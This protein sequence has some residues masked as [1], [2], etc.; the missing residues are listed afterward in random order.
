MK[1]LSAEELFYLW[2]EC[3]N[4]P[5]LAKTLLLLQQACNI[6]DNSVITSMSIGERNARLLQ[7]QEWIFGNKMFH[8]TYCQNCNEKLEWETDTTSMF[9][10]NINNNFIAENYTL[11]FKGYEIS[12]RLINNLDILNIQKNNISHTEAKAS[13]LQ[14]C[15]LEAKKSNKIIAIEKLPNTVF[16]AIE[17]QMAVNDPQANMQF[18]LH[19]PACKHSW[20]A[21][22][23]I[24]NFFW[25]EVNIWAERM[26]QEIYILSHYLHWTEK[27]ILRM[28]A[29]RRQKYLQMIYA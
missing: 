19:C 7:L 9:L 11:Q 8:I 23:D 21:A 2:D 17:K 28:P 6:S 12:Y 24:M 4:M 27:D 18:N 5:V 26:M 14:S 10:Q 3:S 20:Q 22:F 25:E 1:A 16:D 29:Q 13:L 15:L